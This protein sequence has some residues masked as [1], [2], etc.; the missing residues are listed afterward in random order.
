M[1]EQSA[2]DQKRPRRRRMYVVELLCIDS[3]AVG[4]WEA[5]GGRVGCPKAVWN[6]LPDGGKGDSQLGRAL[7]PKNR[8]DQ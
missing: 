7:G 5:N 8:N 1:H 4:G 3:S 2:L 6:Q